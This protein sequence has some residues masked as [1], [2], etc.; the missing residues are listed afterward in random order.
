[1]RKSSAIAVACVVSLAVPAVAEAAP[2]QSS[3]TVRSTITQF[4]ELRGEVRFTTPAGWTQTAG[5][6]RHSYVKFRVAE[7]ACAFDVRVSMRGRSTKLP[8]RQQVFWT[9]ATFGRGTG[10]DRAWATQ[11]PTL[12]GGEGLPDVPGASGRA[13]IEVAPKRF[14]YLNVFAALRDCDPASADAGQALG[15][16]GR[17]VKQVNHVLAKAKT[18]L[19]VVSTG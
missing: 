5:G 14:A 4:S 8:A 7:G 3:F 10:S 2:K 1:M 11:G 13:A 17:T 9:S 19:R 15:V 12:S 16:D 18:S 6:G